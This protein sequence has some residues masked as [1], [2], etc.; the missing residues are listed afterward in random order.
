[1]LRKLHLPFPWLVTFFTYLLVV[2]LVFSPFLLSVCMISLVV[3]SLFR[4]GVSRARTPHRNEQPAHC[5]EV[6]FAHLE[7]MGRSAVSGGGAGT[8]TPDTR[9]MIPLL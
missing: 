4:P 1:M 7:A 6:T 5:S 8:R 3:L 9:I 2:A